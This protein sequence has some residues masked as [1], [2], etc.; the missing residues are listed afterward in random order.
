M[1]HEAISEI[2][3]Q[4]IPEVSDTQIDLPINA[5]I[6]ATWILNREEKLEAYRSATEC[7]NNNEL[8]ELATDWIN[9]YGALPKPVEF[10]I[11][12][13]K[14]KLLAKKCGF[15]KIKLKKPNIVIETTLKNSTFKILK[16]S[17]ASSVQSKFSF[18][19]GEQLSVI[20]IR[21]LGVTEVQYQIDQLMDWFGSFVKEINNFEKDLIIK[22]EN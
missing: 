3:G 13:M 19:E 20:T 12:I 11:M 21:G 14:L 5:F 2:S 15:N 9:R 10:L 18:H 7:S 8:T 17:L 16:N 4:E 6:P 1:L 22:K